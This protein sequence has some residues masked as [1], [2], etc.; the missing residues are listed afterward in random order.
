VNALH[1][2]CVRLHELADPL[3][4]TFCG[5]GRETKQVIVFKRHISRLSSLMDISMSWPMSPLTRR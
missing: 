3:L 4:S 2:P 5:N 1:L